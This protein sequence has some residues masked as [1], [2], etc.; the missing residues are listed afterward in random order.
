MIL[1]SGRY[2]D[3]VGWMS[4]KL[5]DN[6]VEKDLVMT[7]RYLDNNVETYKVRVDGMHFPFVSTHMQPAQVSHQQE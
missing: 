1:Q 2:F 4:A 3:T 5:D 6:T 7:R